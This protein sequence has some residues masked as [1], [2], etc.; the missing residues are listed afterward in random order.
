MPLKKKSLSESI[1]SDKSAQG[2]DFPL[3]ES[4]F[5]KFRAFGAGFPLDIMQFRAERNYP[6]Y[7]S[8]ILEI[9]LS[10]E[11]PTSE[12]MSKSTPQK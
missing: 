4:D 2:G 6:L 12:P 10:V 8:K 9:Y 11:I 1:A 5:K 3:L 7:F